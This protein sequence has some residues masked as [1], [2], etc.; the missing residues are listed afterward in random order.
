MRML[1]RPSCR[2]E[3][4]ETALARGGEAHLT[5]RGPGSSV[6]DFETY[7]LLRGNPKG[8]HLERWRDANGCGKLFFAARCNVT[9][10]VPGTSPTRT[11]APPPNML[12]SQEAR[13]S[14]STCTLAN[15]EG[16]D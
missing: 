13:L 6:V 7:L 11:T 8:V 1:P 10:E 2:V 15:R 14:D 5:R 3:A 12:D 16:A 9:S 4:D